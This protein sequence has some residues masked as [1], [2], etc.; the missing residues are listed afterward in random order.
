M[1][2]VPTEVLSPGLKRLLD[3]RKLIGLRNSAHSLVKLMN[4]VDG[5]AVIVSSYT[6]PEYAVSMAAVFELQ[7]STALLL[8][9]TEGEVVADARRLPQMDGFV[10]GER[11]TLQEGRKARRAAGAAQGSGCGKH[12]RIHPRGAAGA[13]PIPES[14]SLQVEHIL[15][16]A[17]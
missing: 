14:V 15:R 5:P 1:A 3:A 9:G 6:H 4:P 7:R 10:R 8:R 16:L 13:W 2:F 12:G 17:S 11:I